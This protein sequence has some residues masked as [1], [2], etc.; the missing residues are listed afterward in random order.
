[1]R[2]EYFGREKYHLPL[3]KLRFLKAEEER[4]DL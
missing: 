1:M 2:E 3:I 4:E